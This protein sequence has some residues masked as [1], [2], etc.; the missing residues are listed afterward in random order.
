MISLAGRIAERMA[1]QPDDQGWRRMR[2]PEQAT[3]F[4]EAGHITVGVAVGWHPYE[5]NLDPESLKVETGA[6]VLAYASIGRS[7]DPPKRQGSYGVMN[8]DR[9]TS[10]QFC[11]LM[12][13][14]WKGALKQLRTLKAATRD[15]V[16][17][18]W[19]TIR[20]LAYELERSRRLDQNQIAELIDRASKLPVWEGS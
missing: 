20:H 1:L 18:N 10:A 13:G 2:S 15:L 7:P 4:H 11:L 3:C 8:S 14:S 5:L 6:P 16:E 17:Q 19:S 12:S 9:R